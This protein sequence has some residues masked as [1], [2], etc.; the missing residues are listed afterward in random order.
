MAIDEVDQV[1]DGLQ[2]AIRRT[3]VDMLIWL[4]YA[5]A[6]LEQLAGSTLRAHHIPGRSAAFAGI[7]AEH[8]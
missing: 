6:P 7:P 8:E 2:L 3:D 4:R 5:S 1:L